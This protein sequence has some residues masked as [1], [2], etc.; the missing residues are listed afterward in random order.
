VT[1]VS[2]DVTIATTMY[3]ADGICGGEWVDMYTV[4]SETWDYW[5]KIMHE[6]SGVPLGSIRNKVL[7]GLEDVAAGRI[8]GKQTPP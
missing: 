5:C 7:K 1:S 3:D 8:S 4:T 6:L 2:L